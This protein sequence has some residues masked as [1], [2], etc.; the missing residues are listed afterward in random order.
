MNGDLYALLG[1]LEDAS[2]DELKKAYRS[3]ARDSHPDRNPGDATAEARFKAVADAYRVLA[4]PDSRRVYDA[5]RRRQREAA[6]PVASILGVRRQAWAKPAKERGDDLRY[7]VR[8]GFEQ[9]A[10]G[11]RETLELP[12]DEP[13]KPCGGTGAAPGMPPGPC[14]DCDGEGTRTFASGFFHQSET[15]RTCNGTGRVV[16]TTCASCAGLGTR[17]RNRQVVVDIPG[18]IDDKARLRLTGEGRPGAN[19]GP[20]GDLIVVIDIE[21][22]PF[23]ERRGHDIYVEVPI[24]VGQAVLGAQIEIPTLEGRM[25]MRVPPGTQTGRIFRL[26]GQGMRRRGTEERGDQKI[27]V[28]VETPERLTE[29]QRALMERWVSLEP[30]NG[31]DEVGAYRETLRKLYS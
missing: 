22:H 3:I 5:G 30:L 9:A 13:C 16:R 21:S 17:A 26:K 25:R 31:D 1:V 28:V 11:T 19:G 12:F 6:D 14:P 8:L 4:D 23:F 29:E 7:T 27:R 10:L 15:C 2:A 24:S 18:G 20:P